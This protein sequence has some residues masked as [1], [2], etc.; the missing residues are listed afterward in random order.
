M[1]SA[2]AEVVKK[3]AAWL[4]VLA[5]MVAVQ[6]FAAGL[7]ILTK[8]ILSN[9]AFIFAVMAYRH[10]VAAFCVAPFAFY[11]ERGNVRK[12]KRLSVWLW[13]FLNALI[14]ITVA[15]SL[16]YYGLKD[17][18]ATYATNFLNLVPIVTFVL[19]IILRV[20]KLGLGSKTG[21]AKTAGAILCVGGALVTTLYKG[22]AFHFHMPHHKSHH[23]LTTLHTVKHSW[24]RGTMLLIGSCISYA[25]WYMLQVKLH[26]VFP[27]KY[28]AT[29]ITCI[30]AFVQCAIV[31]LCIKRDTTAWGLGWNMELLTI[32]Y[33]GALST[34]ATFCLISWAVS[35]R[36]PSYPPMFNPLALIFV[37]ISEALILGTNISLGTILGMVLIIMGLYSFLWAKNNEMRM[38][39][40]PLTNAVACEEGQIVSESIEMQSAAAPT[41]TSQV[42]IPQ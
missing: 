40:L 35:K 11:F 34:A 10:V 28:W 42:K 33:S 14:G 32:F 18:T 20:E 38:N 27:S 1:A 30:I 36:G 6:V 21:K 19:S 8:V 37:A 16:F 39:R 29:M 23:P 25:A 9:G 31:G 15:M 26:N 13:V 2:V 41:T 3:R 17:T 5:G 4:Q 24:T 22:M 12:M 7:Q